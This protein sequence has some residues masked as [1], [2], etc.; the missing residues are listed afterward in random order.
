M[1]D[2]GDSWKELNEKWQKHR[3]KKQKW[4][5][6]IVESMAAIYGFEWEAIQPYQLRITLNGKRL[7]Y[8]PQKGRST[9]VGS[10]KWFVITDIEQFILT[11]LAKEN[12]KGSN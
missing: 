11:E 6:E 10:N 7:D 3:Q 1:G 9:W 5:T 4:G 2:I 12:G 8:F